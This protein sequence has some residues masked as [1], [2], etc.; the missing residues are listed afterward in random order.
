MSSLQSP[1]MF[2]CMAA[3]LPV[4]QW[5]FITGKGVSNLCSP[6]DIVDILVRICL[7]CITLDVKEDRA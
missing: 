7:L 1:Y 5:Q 3:L 4:V 2:F 6:L